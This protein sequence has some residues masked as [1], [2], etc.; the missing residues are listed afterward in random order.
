M[1]NIINKII[2]TKSQKEQLRQG[3]ISHP[4]A[5]WPW[6]WSHNQ[7]RYNRLAIWNDYR[8]SLYKET[9]APII[10]L[11]NANRY[12][13]D[14]SRPPIPSGTRFYR[15]GRG[16]TQGTS[17]SIIQGPAI[18]GAH[19]RTSIAPRFRF[20]CQSCLVSSDESNYMDDALPLYV[21][22]S[23]QVRLD[24]RKAWALN[25]STQVHAMGLLILIFLHQ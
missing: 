24:Q 25:Q 3:S 5:Y 8:S 2:N 15:S 17:S 21:D 20:A 23:T 11:H 22:Q 7:F 14:Y 13:F 1:L 9:G 4:L 16:G 10:N 19:R 12:S 18:S 6:N